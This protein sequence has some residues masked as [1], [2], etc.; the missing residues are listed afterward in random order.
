MMRA[1]VVV[2]AI[3][4]TSIALAI[5]SIYL[6]LFLLGEV[7]YTI[8]VPQFF[9]AV[10]LPKTNTYG[11]IAAI[12]VGLFLRIGAGDPLIGIPTFIKYPF[13]SDTYGQLFPFKTLCMLS[14]LTTL[15]AVSYLA[16]FLFLSGT[17]PLS[18]DFLRRFREC[19]SK[20]QT[21]SLNTNKKEEETHL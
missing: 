1:T 9:C 15:V 21:P 17:V 10:F 13:Y 20:K 12:A 2:S 19:S 3:I 8:L 11:S 5:Q 6:L 18:A 7:L 16:R 4:S 14:S